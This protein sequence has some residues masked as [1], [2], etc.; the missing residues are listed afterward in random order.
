M[1][2]IIIE[3][4]NGDELIHTDE[5]PFCQDIGSCDCHIDQELLND[6]IAKPLT[7]GMM[8]YSEARKLWRG[9]GEVA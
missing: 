4:E 2:P 5:H 3:Y 1:Q 7:D 8:T 9:G 6:Y